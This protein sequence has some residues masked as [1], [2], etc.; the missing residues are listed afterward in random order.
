LL[1][2]YVASLPLFRYNAL[3]LYSSPARIDLECLGKTFSKMDLILISQN[4]LT[5]KCGKSH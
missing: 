5:K 1:E 2:Q 3:R 4:I